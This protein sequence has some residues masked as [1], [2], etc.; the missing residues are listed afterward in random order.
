MALLIRLLLG[1]AAKESELRDGEKAND[2]EEIPSKASSDEGL[3]PESA[4][5]AT[6]NDPQQPAETHERILELLLRDQQLSDDLAVQLSC[7]EA[8][9]Q[10]AEPSEPTEKLHVG[11]V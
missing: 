2:E 3:G 9:H 7:D 10:M 5:L 4:K 8:R 1:A 11:P 6:E